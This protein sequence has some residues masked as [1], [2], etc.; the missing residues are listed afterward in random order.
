MGAALVGFLLRARVRRM[1]AARA[2][3]AAAPPGAF[4]ALVAAPK[5]PD[6]RV[7]VVVGTVRM[8]TCVGLLLFWLI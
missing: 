5:P 1:L 2:D 3:I 4:A 8:H 6:A 7:G